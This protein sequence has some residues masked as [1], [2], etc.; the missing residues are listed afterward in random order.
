MA[1]SLESIIRQMILSTLRSSKMTSASPGHIN[2]FIGIDDGGIIDVGNELDSAVSELGGSSKDVESKESK[3]KSKEKQVS[4]KVGEVISI[5]N[6]PVALVGKALPLL[7]HAALVAL[8]LAMAPLIVDILTKPGGPLDVRFKRILED[9]FNSFLSRQ[10]QKD[11]SMGTRQVIVQSKV[12]FTAENGVNN[13][14]TQ[15][16]IREGG[17]NLERESRINMK[18]HSKGLW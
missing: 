5:A 3:E 4:G 13:Y 8:A 9:E 2:Y 10:T 15:K 12:G 7:P 18:D 1:S 16:G 17:T 11:T 14:N 6:N